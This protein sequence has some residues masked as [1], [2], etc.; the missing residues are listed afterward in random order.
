VSSRRR[1]RAK[2]CGDKK[3]FAKMNEAMMVARK[4]NIRAYKCPFC[5]R[6]HV[7]HATLKQRL[8]LQDRGVSD[9]RERR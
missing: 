9:W 8:E 4:L 7:G 6:W 2:I 3:A 1:V 5:R